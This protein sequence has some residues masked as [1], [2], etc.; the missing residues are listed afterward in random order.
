MGTLDGN[1][2][3]ADEVQLRLGR[4]KFILYQGFPQSGI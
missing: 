4:F 2:Q 1:P 3:R